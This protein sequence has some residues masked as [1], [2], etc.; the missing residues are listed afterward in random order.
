MATSVSTWSNEGS[1]CSTRTG[2]AHA[3]T[4]AIRKINTA[5]RTCVFT[6]TSWEFQLK[7]TERMALHVFPIDGKYA[8]AYRFVPKLSIR[9]SHFTVPISSA[10]QRGPAARWVGRRGRRFSL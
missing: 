7:Q 1:D 4:R 10:G 5:K 3:A 2:E 6:P 9:L 8:A